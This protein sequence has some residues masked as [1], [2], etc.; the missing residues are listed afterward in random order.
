MDNHLIELVEEIEAEDQY[1]K[2]NRFHST[3]NQP[4]LIALNSTDSTEQ[5]SI[6]SFSKFNVNLPR[7]ALDVESIQLVNANIPMCVP[8]IPDTSLVFWYYRLSVYSGD[9]PNPNN[10]YFVRLLPSYYQ[11]EFIGATSY[12]CNQ[13]FA[14]YEDLATQLALACSRDLTNDNLAVRDVDEDSSTYSYHFLPNEISLPYD[15]SINKF[16]MIGTNATTQPAYVVWNS[17]TIYG[18][19]STVEYGGSTYQ[20]INASNLNNQPNISPTY[21]KLVYVDFIPEWDVNTPY[22]KGQYASRYN[23]YLYYALND[24]IG[25]DPDG[26]PDWTT[27]L[28]TSTYYRYLPTGYKDP[29][30]FA[31]QGDAYQQWNEYSLFEAGKILEYKGSK[32]IAETQSKGFVPFTVNNAY[33]WNN[34][35][36]FSLGDYVTYNGVLYQSLVNGNVDNQPNISPVFWSP[37][38]WDNLTDY[39]LGDIVMYGGNQYKCIT[40]VFT[41]NNVANPAPNIT[42]NVWFPLYWNNAT[43]YSVGDIISYLGV[44]YI[45]KKPSLNQ[46]P[47][48]FSAYWSPQTFWAYAGSPNIF[49]RPDIVGIHAITKQFDYVDVW[50]GI[51]QYPFPVGI[52]GQPFVTNPKRILNTILGFAWNGIFNPELFADLNTFVTPTATSTTIT[53]LYNRLRPVPQYFVRFF[54]GSSLRSS[55]A[56]TTQ[57]YTAEGYAK[58]VYTNILS[59]YASI[60]YGSTLNTTTNTNLLATGTMDCGNLG[61]SFFNPIVNNPLKVSGSDLYSIQL[62][63]YDECGDP[64]YMTNNAVVSI[65]LKVMYAKDTENK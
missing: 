18:L 60:V 6:S 16:Q 29:N 48:T 41:E 54:T 43:S 10:L 20:S 31:L 42:P 22:R 8:N 14:S 52:A 62:E 40:A 65:V 17:G 38:D 1:R 15:S 11:P 33:T 24:N 46:T 56:T 26:G 36:D 47:S 45:A 51:P 3:L 7:P 55:T 21:W 34:V 53:Q 19:N 13:T 4:N 9:V 12:G 37:N 49:P 64:F 32:W 35:A 61:I 23:L 63:F 59:I 44:F 30:I 57:T 28:P 25:Q 39:K 27:L 2:S 5:G 50:E 58:L